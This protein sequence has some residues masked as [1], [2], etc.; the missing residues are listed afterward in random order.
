ML[1]VK[2]NGK[3]SSIET[4]YE[5]LSFGKFLKICRSKGNEV[6]TVAVLLDMPEETI[7][8]AKFNGL[9]KVINAINFMQHP[10]VLDEKPTR[11]GKYILPTAIDFETVEQYQMLRTEINNAA[12]ADNANDQTEFLALYA[13]IYLQPI[14]TNEPFDMTKAREFSKELFKYPCQEVMSVGSFFMLKLLNTQRDLKKNFRLHPILQ[15]KPK[16]VLKRLM[17]RLASM[18]PWTTSPGT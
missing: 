7:A 18:L 5:E 10:P 13:A 12:K 4:R 2:V 16:P 11:I 8:K 6:A 1:T 9:E 17:T 14:A 3:T 15:K